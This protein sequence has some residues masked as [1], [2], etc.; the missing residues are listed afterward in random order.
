M[1]EFIAPGAAAAG[2][3]ATQASGGGGP[4]GF[5]TRPISA[6]GSWV[7]RHTQIGNFNPG[8]G[9]FGAAVANMIPGLVNVG[10]QVGG[11]V[12]TGHEGQAIH[13]LGQVGQGLWHGA[14]DTATDVTT[15][16]GIAPWRQQEENLLGKLPGHYT[17][18]SLYQYA[19]HKGEGLGGGLFNDVANLALVADGAGAIAKSGAIGEVAAD[20]L[21]SGDVEAKAAIDAQ[22]PP[23]IVKQARERQI[24]AKIADK[25]VDTRDPA[26]FSDA[27]RQR[28]QAIEKIDKAR[29][30]ATNL[31][32][33]WHALRPFA[34]AAREN[35][36]PSETPPEGA[37]A[38]EAVSGT[39]G[40]ENAPKPGEAPTGAVEGTEPPP[41]KPGY[42]RIYHGSDFHEPAG[43][44]GSW[45]TT[46]KP[47]GRAGYEHW[48]YTDVATTNVERKLRT[49]KEDVQAHVAAGG[50]GGQPRVGKDLLLDPSNPAQSAWMDSAQPYTANREGTVLTAEGVPG[51]EMYHP[52][53][54][55][56]EAEINKAIDKAQKVVEKGGP[57][58]AAA[59]EIVRMLNEAKGEMVERTTEPPPTPV[60]EPSAPAA[61]QGKAQAIGNWFTSKGQ[62][63]NVPRAYQS[64][65]EQTRPVPKWVRDIT[66]KMPEPV[67]RL[68]AW[69]DAHH[70]RIDYMRITREQSRA[71]AVRA[72]E[73][74]NRPEIV[75]LKQ[76]ATTILQE[77]GV[78]LKVA[79]N[80]VGQ[81]VRAY[82]TRPGANA[83]EAFEA[84]R[85]AIEEH[86]PG[87]TDSQLGYTVHIPDEINTPEWRAQ[88]YPLAEQYK[89]LRLQASEAMGQ[90]QFLKDR[91][92][93]PQEIDMP[94]MTKREVRIYNQARH[95]LLQAANLEERQVPKQLAGLAK[96]RVAVED[97]VGRSVETSRAAMEAMANARTD[98]D[99]SRNVPE[100]LNT[101]EKLTAVAAEMAQ[102]T[103]E[104][105]TVL[106]N[107]T[108]TPS[109]G[110]F[111]TPGTGGQGFVVGTM[112]RP[113]ISMPLNEWQAIDPNGQMHG[114]NVISNMAMG[115]QDAIGNPGV[116]F[117]T[118]IDEQ[119]NVHLDMVQFLDGE[120]SR[121]H[122]MT[123]AAVRGQ[124]TITDLGSQDTI[125]VQLDP[126][127]S[128]WFVRTHGARDF[129]AAKMRALADDPNRPLDQDSVDRFMAWLDT[130]AV[131]QHLLHPDVYSSPDA[132]YRKGFNVEGATRVSPV[133]GALNDMR[134]RIP[135]DVTHLKGLIKDLVVKGGKESKWY[136]QQHDYIERILKQLPETTEVGWRQIGEDGRVV[137]QQVPTR[138]LLYSLVAVN[139]K[140]ANPMDNF[141]GALASF[142]N[143]H[144]ARQQI[145]DMVDL[146]KQWNEMNVK[147]RAMP[148]KAVAEQPAIIQLLERG[149][150]HLA[151]RETAAV[152]DGHLVGNW[153]LDFVMNQLPE[154]GFSEKGGHD[155]SEVPTE[156]V[157]KF[158]GDKERAAM[159]YFG[160]LANAKFR[161]YYENLIDPENSMSVTLDNH[162]GR[163][164]GKSGNLFSTPGAWVQYADL[165]RNTAA[166]LSKDL[167]TKVMPH[168]VQAA[169]WY[170][171]K[172]HNADLNF[173]YER[174]LRL[175]AIDMVKNGT[176][177]PE[178]DPW[179]AELDY[180]KKEAQTPPPEAK[181]ETEGFTKRKLKLRFAEGAPEEIAQAGN[182]PAK[183]YTREVHWFPGAS[184]TGTGTMTKAGLAAV[185]KADKYRANLEAVWEKN[186]RDPAKMA[187]FMQ[188]ELDKTN[189][190]FVKESHGG[191]FIEGE[192]RKNAVEAF[193]DLGID[194]ATALNEMRDE[195][196]GQFVPTKGLVGGTIRLF[197][198]ADL[199]TLF[200]E[201]GHLLR[202]LTTGDD[203]ALL[204]RTYGVVNHAWT[205][206]QEEDFVHDFLAAASEQTT[207]PMSRLRQ[208]LAESYQAF[209]ENMHPEIAGFW[210]QALKPELEATKTPDFQLSTGET[211][212]GLTGRNELGKT[213]RQRQQQTP[214]LAGI[215]T[216]Q[217]V[218]KR[219]ALGEMAIDEW[220]KQ[221]SRQRAADAAAARGRAHVADLERMI[222]EQEVPA[223][224]AAD[225]LRRQGI[226]KMDKLQQRLEDPA[227]SRV[228]P[229]WQ[230]MVTAAKELA[231]AIEKHPELEPIVAEFPKT[232]GQA[233]EYAR[234]HGVD[235]TYMPDLT[236]QR[237]R[238]LIAGTAKL[239]GEGTRET[240]QRF[241][242]GARKQRNATLQKIGGVDTSIEALVAGLNQVTQESRTNQI[243]DWIDRRV[244]QPL[245][246]D[247]N[248]KRLG[249]PPGWVEWDPVR[250]GM[251]GTEAVGGEE[252]RLA[253]PGATRMIPRQVMDA[254]KEYSGDPPTNP[255]YRGLKMMTDPWRY[256]MLT[257][258][259]GFYLK[260]FQG[261]IFLAAIAGG[262][263]LK[264]WSE[265]W[266]AARE[267][268][269]NLP[270][271][272]GQNIAYAEAGE[273]GL[274][275]YPSLKDAFQTGGKVEGMRYLGDKAHNVIATTDAFA[276][277]VAY[278]ARKH[279][280]Y[281]D[282]EAMQ[283]A[284]D[285]VI[286]YGNLSNTEKYMVRAI[287]PF[288]SFE[289]GVLKIAYRLP[290][291]HPLVASTLM[292][293]SKW[294][295]EQA[296]DDQGNPLP[297]RYQGVVDLPLL[298]PTD[299]QKFSPFKDVAALTTP[300]GIVQSLQYATQAVVRAG[301]GVA[302]P[303]THAKVKIDK[304]GRLVP[305]VT[306]GSQLAASFSGGPQGQVIQGG[307]L[308]HFFGIPTVS[309]DTLNRAG[310]RNVLSQAELANASTA[311][312]Q[313]AAMTPINTLAMQQNLRGVINQGGGPQAAALPTNAQGQPTIT[314]QQLADAVAKAV[315]DEKAKAATTR[316]ANLAS[317][318]TT[319]HRGGGGSHRRHYSGRG[320]R[321]SRKIFRSGLGRFRSG[322]S[323]F[324]VR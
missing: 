43:T 58:G 181:G 215:E 249:A 187:D 162:M 243:V 178:S 319:T 226:S 280:G 90:S 123:L 222:N 22:A 103:G 311:E 204:E 278:F 261:H 65:M 287:V 9:S 109:T 188:N 234:A 41:P 293:I 216:P 179:A 100:S 132:F 212:R 81:F 82:V 270:E 46:Q 184:T 231:A 142:R 4:L 64:Y 232:F 210:Q 42:T 228:P 299:M 128:S 294:Q 140:R 148:T 114:A 16:G 48:Q 242:S 69:S 135:G 262:L 157:S 6:L 52:G 295:E 291:D 79:N 94:R 320:T 76:Q 29:T 235:P 197:K 250:R 273:P 86:M 153:N 267:G 198:N 124:R 131:R 206:A 5:I 120:T 95:K 71:L 156:L 32:Q 113:V 302:A 8:I 322:K 205:V 18:T 301:L 164:W 251:L 180:R 115:Y 30:G 194:P 136:F 72:R 202:A 307:P 125:P 245:P 314:Q 60:E 193:G 271:V 163:L 277:A 248:G 27:V 62:M 89:Q 199:G 236:P 297:E 268:Y 304:F 305:D 323:S 50:E 211:I 247:E 122:A 209:G 149:S 208:V 192:G 85:P 127:A 116:G 150:N 78:P 53:L 213:M 315:A 137:T 14:L 253:V 1:P 183:T 68:L 67:Q 101:P 83:I 61:A 279:K 152:L 13:E 285:A 31:L 218:Y 119:G 147:E 102:R 39:P 99:R 169:L 281:S 189:R 106:Y 145:N 74:E 239:G 70:Q 133:E 118:A 317:G 87:M 254:I 75:A 10:L 298:G 35:L 191:T 77:Q 98:F 288:Y 161:S 159:E 88:M 126:N 134:V 170:W 47:E 7:N 49:V 66:E 19:T 57:K 225:M 259:P 318:K 26:A 154:Y 158:H 214:N 138:E 217:Q 190:A 20:A 227:T 310:Q 175:Q 185:A 33:P 34:R 166:E 306:L 117:A 15:F 168:E 171:T 151:N 257:L 300:D 207:G 233:M 36:Y 93:T 55:M 260:H 264:A 141:A 286:D 230:P 59:A 308:S 244:A 290:M 266:K 284:M 263:D 283:Y 316:A 80:I 219:G 155:M 220:A 24:E 196:Y 139:S 195:I 321:R 104:Q 313:Q 44:Q 182:N 17:P 130:Q 296:V 203:L 112:D 51:P 172:Y 255:I 200:H 91:G 223:Q 258:N 275:G 167:G 143:I 292:A 21:K 146:I 121:D 37:V 107:P 129:K 201:G 224:A 186:G 303:G 23:E 110:A 165:V 289:K 96:E 144:L 272:T 240:G 177:T 312:Q 40:A 28:I 274:V 63:E 324:K 54:E 25:A 276:R 246:T 176:W 2:N 256:L 73:I 265:A 92:L 11:D 238:Q 56:S 252:G 160:G 221:R 84:A 111:V 45:W 173:A 309:Q 12:L 237:V 3:A 174:Q 229:K 105:D 97:M 282:M 108:A 269:V 38:P 241:I